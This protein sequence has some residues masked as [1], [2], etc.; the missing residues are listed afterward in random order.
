[1]YRITI[2]TKG[3]QTQLK[4]WKT[5]RLL[6]YSVHR[7]YVL[8][9]DVVVQ[10]H[11]YVWFWWKRCNLELRK[12]YFPHFFNTSANQ[13]YHGDLPDRRYYGPD[14]MSNDWY[15]DFQR[16]YTEKSQQEDYRFHFRIELLE[17]CGLDVRLLRAGCE[18]FRREFQELAHFDPFQ[19]TT[20]TSACSR[21][22]RKS[23]LKRQTIASEPVTGWRLNTHYSLAAL[24]WLEWQGER[25][26][27]PLQHVGSEGEHRNRDGNRT[28]YVD[29]FDYV[30]RTVYELNGCFWH[31]FQECY[32]QARDKHHQ[33]VH[34]R[35]LEDVYRATLAWQTRLRALGYQI[36]DRNHVG[37]SM[38]STQDR[39]SWNYKY[40]LELRFESSLKP[41]WCFLWWPN[42]R[43]AFVRRP[44]WRTVTLLLRFHVPLSLGQQVRSLSYQAPDIHLPTL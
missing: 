26:G 33:Q 34:G 43:R 39:F 41:S 25:L 37:A 3:R 8:L 18:V 22:L 40:G 44:S 21:D 16:W 29:G 32:P 10:F 35:T 31:G 9:T 7:L 4:T 42:Q 36:R 15:R 28:Y 17:Y 1:M 38:D 19:H 27:R 6:T 20:I 11:Q 13:T 14:I 23:R 30:T 5:S 12:G 24:E 2:V